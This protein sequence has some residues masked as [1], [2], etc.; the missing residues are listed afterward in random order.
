MLSTIF[1]HNEKKNNHFA[2]RRRSLKARPPP[3]SKSDKYY[4][5]NDSKY[6]DL[7]DEQIPTS[8]SLLDCMSRTR[9]LWEYK[10]QRDLKQGKNV[11]VV[12]H[13]NTL[14][15]LAKIIDGMLSFA[16]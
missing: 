5:G 11:M 7:I 2:Y 12:A 4:P 15:G 14:R 1:T 8:E 9:P 13:A 10:I 6:S 3:I 16:A